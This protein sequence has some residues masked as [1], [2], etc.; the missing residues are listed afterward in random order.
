M[1]LLAL[2]LLVV[3]KFPILA[4]T[5]LSAMMKESVSAEAATLL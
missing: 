2:S 4:I 1:K 3:L 5:L